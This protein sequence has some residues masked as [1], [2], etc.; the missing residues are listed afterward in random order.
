[1]IGDR[2]GSM[3]AHAAS[4]PLR[5][6]ALGEGLHERDLGLLGRVV[7]DLLHADQHQAGHPIRIGD[8]GSQTDRCA[9]TRASEHGLAHAETIQ[10]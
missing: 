2:S 8:R 1:M 9:E 4:T 5:A 6:H 3:G 10:Q 7:L